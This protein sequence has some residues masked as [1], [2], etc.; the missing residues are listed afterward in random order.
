MASWAVVFVAA[1]GLHDGCPGGTCTHTKV[2]VGVF[3]DPPSQITSLGVCS[4]SRV[5][6]PSLATSRRTLWPEVGSVTR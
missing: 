1:G 2:G 5:R 3:D 6:T 4:R